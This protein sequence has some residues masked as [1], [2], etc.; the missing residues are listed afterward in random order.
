MDPDNFPLPIE[1]LIC[2]LLPG[3]ERRADRI[4]FLRIHHA[5]ESAQMRLEDLGAAL[6][7]YLRD[8]DPLYSARILKGAAAMTADKLECLASELR[9]SIPR[10]VPVEHQ[11]YA[12]ENP[13]EPEAS[14]P[15]TPF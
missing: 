7:D 5:A 14:E 8:P 11:R 10:I 13:V 3:E 9:K 2:D 6:S 15:D 1:R 12:A 4:T